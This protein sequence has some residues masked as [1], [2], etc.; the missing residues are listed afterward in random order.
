MLRVH[1][2]FEDI[3]KV[4]QTIRRFH[5]QR[6]PLSCTINT[7]ANALYEVFC[8][9]DDTAHE[10]MRHACFDYLSLGGE[11]SAGPISLLSGLNPRPT[12]MIH[13]FFRVALFGV[14]NLLSKP[15]LTK[16]WL[17]MRVLIVA[18]CIIFPIVR[19]EGFDMIYSQLFLSEHSVKT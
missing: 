12:F 11:C 16:I 3:Q 7:L 18:V 15:S 19:D 6:K 9:K 2:T 1:D 14:G 10:E 17:S 13:H 5:I 8:Y 4:D